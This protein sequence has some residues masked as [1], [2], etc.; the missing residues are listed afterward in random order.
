ML[1]PTV[2]QHAAN[3]SSQVNGIAVTE[4]GGIKTEMHGQGG[5]VVRQPRRKYISGK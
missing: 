5:T 3:W 2:Q 4:E 1:D